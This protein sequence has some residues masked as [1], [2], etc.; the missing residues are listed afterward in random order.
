MFELYLSQK[1]ETLSGKQ[2]QLKLC[3]EFSTEVEG[4]VLFEAPLSPN[5]AH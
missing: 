3:E 2:W 4:F 1:T 5:I